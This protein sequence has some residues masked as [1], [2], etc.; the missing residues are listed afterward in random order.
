M[1]IDMHHHWIPE[2]LSRVLRQRKEPP[3]IEC[4]DDGREHLVTNVIGGF[5]LT[6]GFDSVERRIAEMDEGGVDRAV[7]SLIALGI[8]LMPIGQG[9]PMLRVY[10]DS[11]S[12][13]CA[14]HPDR[15][16]ALAAVPYTDVAAAVE[17]FE[18]AMDL[19]GMVGAQLPGDG[20]LSQKRAE[21][22]RP[23]FEAANRRR[24]HLLVHYGR[25]PDDPE[26]PRPDFSDN[27]TPRQGTLDMQSRLSSNMIT[28]VLTD[29]LAD[30]PNVSVQSHNLGGNIPLEVER[31]DHRF[32]I[33]NPG[34]ELPSAKFRHMKMVVDCNSYGPRGI[35]MAVAAYGADKIVFGTD[36]TLFGMEWSKKAV[37]EA[38]ISDAEREAIL[39]AN[40]ARCIAPNLHRDARAAA[41]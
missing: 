23:L 41:E 2:G 29:F 15:F 24:A 16:S 25:Q 6:E 32:M 33:T 7:L 31:L 36:G 38:R 3:L 10:N 40:A 5:P 35:E 12:R 1:T 22:W 18:R 37:A 14:A 30:F 19:P 34:E 17:E 39:H 27:R 9:L 4:R 8:E 21:R 11:V 13:M 20:F 28:F 26:A